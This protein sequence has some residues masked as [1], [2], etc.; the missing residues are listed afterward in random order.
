MVSSLSGCADRS[1]EL[2]PGSVN[3]E[4][5]FLSAYYEEYQKFDPIR[6]FS[7]TEIEDVEY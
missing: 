4:G 5:E 6:C 3:A 7:F 2:S 1:I